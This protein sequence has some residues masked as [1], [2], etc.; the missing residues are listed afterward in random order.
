MPF[1]LAFR[2]CHSAYKS[3]FGARLAMQRARGDEDPGP[4]A[5]EEVAEVGNVHIGDER[6]A[7]VEIS[8]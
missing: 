7:L 6:E 1:T 4:L 8:G 5:D 3:A 2:R